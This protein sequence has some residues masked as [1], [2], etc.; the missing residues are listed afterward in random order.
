[1]LKVGVV[2]ASGL[3]G[4]NIISILEERKFP[5]KELKLFASSKSKGKE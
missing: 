4:R 5:I 2:G 1:M 3:V